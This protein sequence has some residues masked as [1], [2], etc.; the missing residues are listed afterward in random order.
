MSTVEELRSEIQG[1]EEQIRD[2]E[3][4][5]AS[6][7]KG[8]DDA[9]LTAADVE[10]ALAQ[11]EAGLAAA[12]EELRAAEQEK[13]SLVPQH[14]RCL[15][16]RDQHEKAEQYKKDIAVAEGEL[17]D[18]DAKIKSLERRLQA[19]SASYKTAR[20]RRLLMVNKVTSLVDELRTAVESKIAL[21]LPIDEAEGAPNAIECLNGLAEVTRE[22]ELAIHQWQRCAKELDAV[23][24]MKRARAEQLRRES[25]SNIAAMKAAHDEEILAL[26]QRYNEERESLQADIDRAKR[27]NNENLEALRSTKLLSAKSTQLGAP[28]PNNARAFATPAETLH[29]QKAKDLELEREQ[30]LE[31]IRAT[32]LERQ[33]LVKASKELKQQLAKE[34]TKFA[35]ALANLENR[36]H[37]ERTEAVAIDLENKKLEEACDILAVALRANAIPSTRKSP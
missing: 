25:E 4:V 21:T 37:N 26:V 7:R 23:I 17:R 12:Q 30:L 13:A 14:E 5:L 18:A 9:A 6:K 10:A 24:E 34:E 8:I 36:I 35:T 31:R 11:A 32:S 29:H 27:E 2:K 3:R 28:S 19:V 22:R 1:L 16:N 33:K 20:E 15:Q